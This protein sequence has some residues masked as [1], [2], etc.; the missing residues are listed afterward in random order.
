M[1]RKLA[2]IIALLALLPLLLVLACG[3]SVESAE[4][5]DELAPIWDAWAKLNDSYANQ[6]SLNAEELM[7]GAFQPPQAAESR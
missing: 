6:E 4:N 3:S 7:S 5:V 1:N 2:K